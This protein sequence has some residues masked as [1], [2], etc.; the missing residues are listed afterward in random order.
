MRRTTPR[1]PS[2]DPDDRAGD[3][4]IV[5]SV[6]VSWSQEAAFRRFAGEFSSSWPWRTHSI[7]GKRVARLVLEQWVG[8]RIYEEHVDGRRFQ[9]GTVLEWDPPSRLKFTFHPARDP[10]SAQ[11]VEV[12]FL[13]EA[14]APAS[15]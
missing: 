5:R 11:D 3:L 9:W 8:G 12:R 14:E 10:S 6:L 2:E 4:P 15:S 7:G 13:P 1:R